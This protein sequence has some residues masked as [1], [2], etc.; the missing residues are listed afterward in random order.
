MQ[1]T[2]NNKIAKNYT[3]TLKY[4]NPNKTSKVKLVTDSGEELGTIDLPTTGN[5][6]I[7]KNIK[8]KKGENKIRIIFEDG[9]VNLEYFE[10]K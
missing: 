2:V 9:G 10:I 1:F 5:Y 4:A 6:T 8:L 3:V 7:A